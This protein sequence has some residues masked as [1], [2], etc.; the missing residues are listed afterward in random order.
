LLLRAARGTRSVCGSISCGRSGAA[1]SGSTYVARDRH[2]WLWRPEAVFAAEALAE[3]SRAGLEWSSPAA[4]DRAPLRA[5]GSIPNVAR[6]A[7]QSEK[8]SPTV[9]ASSLASA[10]NAAS[11]SEASPLV[12]P[13]PHQGKL[14]SMAGMGEGGRLAS[15]HMVS[16]GTVSLTSREV[17]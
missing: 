2:G 17:A 5:S 6:R 11:G 1:L 13:I 9:A 7:F 8:S 16:T 14:C 12:H 3:V 4:Y 10:P 15:A